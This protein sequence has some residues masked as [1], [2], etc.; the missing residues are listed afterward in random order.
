[1][2]GYLVAFI[3]LILKIGQKIFTGY[4]KKSKDH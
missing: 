2:F 4:H 1:M 3:Q